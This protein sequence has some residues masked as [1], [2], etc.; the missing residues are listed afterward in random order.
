MGRRVVNQNGANYT[1]AFD[2]LL[3]AAG[4]GFKKGLM[5]EKVMDLK[6]PCNEKFYIGEGEEFGK[7]IHL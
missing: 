4:L 2:S 3:S 1:F 7:C 6:E 5:D